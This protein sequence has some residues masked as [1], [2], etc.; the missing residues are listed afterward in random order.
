[1]PQPEHSGGH[2]ARCGGID[3][4]GPI[5][6]RQTKQAEAVPSAVDFDRYPG[7]TEEMPTAAIARGEAALREDGFDLVAC[8]VTADPDGVE[9]TLRECMDGR[10][11]GV[12]V[13]GADARMARETQ[14]SSSAWETRGRPGPGVRSAAP[15][16]QAT[17]ARRARRSGSLRYRERSPSI[18]RSRHSVR[19]TGFINPSSSARA[20]ISPK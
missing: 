6:V 12:A 5:G 8:Q 2:A 19:V 20:R 10:P 7:R 17:P 9:V 11:F 3:Y 18:R 14:S 13:I 16:A 4:T 15:P 1:M